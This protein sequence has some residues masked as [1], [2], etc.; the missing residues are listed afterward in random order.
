MGEERREGRWLVIG[1]GRTGEMVAE[2][3]GGEWRA[4]IG[5]LA[6]VAKVVYLGS[7]R[8]SEKEGV[9]RFRGRQE[10]G[11]WEVMEIGRR[12]ADGE[13]VVVRGEEA[14][15]GTLNG[16]AKVIGQEKVWLRVRVVEVEGG[17]EEEQAE[18]IAAECRGGREPVVR[19][20]GG[21]RTAE[22]Y[23]A[24]RLEGKGELRERGVYVITGGFGR[25]GMTLAEH[26][27]GDAGRGWCCWGGGWERSG[28][29]RGW[30]E[31]YW[32]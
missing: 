3:M 13:L 14:E 17:S 30:G 10:E 21:E 6:G 22:R 32:G 18:R 23:V 4:E 29:W 28:D 5:E 31:R 20:R 26:L 8:A 9:E 25:V 15:E 11:Y 2:R 16:L 24:E 7:L 12:Q 19:W 27:R 1:G